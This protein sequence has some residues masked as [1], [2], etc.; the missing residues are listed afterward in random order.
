M[1]RNRAFEEVNEAFF[2]K[3]LADTLLEYSD[4]DKE[5]FYKKVKPIKYV[6]DMDDLGQVS[7]EVMKASRDKTRYIKQSFE[8]IILNF[9]KGR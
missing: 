9:K 5:K 7:E 4:I 6:W 3:Q 8:K 2:W 1:R